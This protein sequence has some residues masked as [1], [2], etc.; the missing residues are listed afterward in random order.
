MFSE[1]LEEMIDGAL[2]DGVLT[3]KEREILRRRAT[4]EGVDIDEFDLIM[5]ARLAK[6][7]KAK[8]PPIPPIPPMASGYQRSPHKDYPQ[9]NSK[10]GV[11]RKCPNCGAT[12]METS[13]KCSDCGY[14]FVAVEA[15]R[16]VE[17][18]SKK[19]EEINERYPVSSIK[20]VLGLSSERVEQ[21]YSVIYNFP[22]PL[23]KEDLL[24]FILFLEPKIRTTGMHVTRGDEKIASAYRAK[25]FEC[26]EKAKLFFPDDPMFTP[27][28]QQYTKNKKFRWRN[29]SRSA[30]VLWTFALVYVIIG[31]ILWIILE[32][33]L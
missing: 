25:Y 30:R 20:D 6:S 7:N 21:I 18:F 4:S 33:S 29:L 24:E 22:I 8:V 5:E 10:Y 16:S 23:A 13:V 26:V 17:K 9:H 1:E 28:Y 19:L 3:D 32:N 15:N 11:L 2:A 14:A 27:L 12:V 31:L